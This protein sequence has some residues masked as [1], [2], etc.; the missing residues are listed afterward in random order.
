MADS[1][2][3]SKRAQALLQKLMPMMASCYNAHSTKA[4]WIGGGMV[5]YEYGQSFRYP[6][7]FTTPE[8]PYK[9]SQYHPYPELDEDGEIIRSARCRFGAN[10]MY[11]AQNL[12][13][14]LEYLEVNHDLKY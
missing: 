9:M 12:L 1:R 6:I 13:K 10:D 4:V 2:Q 5:D 11:I 3:L 8:G 7:T 14:V